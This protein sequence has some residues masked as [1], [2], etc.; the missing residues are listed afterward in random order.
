MIV[1]NMN[2]KIINDVE[3]EVVAKEQRQLGSERFKAG[4]PFSECQNAHQ[5]SGYYT[6]LVIAADC[7]TYAYLNGVQR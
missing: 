5:R 6:A 2:S 3:P 7:S 1:V 4:E